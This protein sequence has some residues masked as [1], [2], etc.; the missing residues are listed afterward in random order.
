M[1]FGFT[2]LKLHRIWSW[3]VAGNVGS[4]NVLRKVGMQP[5]GRL[6]E[7]E[8]YKGRYYDTLLFGMLDTEWR[9]QVGE[10]AAER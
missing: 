4:V 6:R 7:N 5:E 1:A 8:W 2:E 3:C 10:K 9:V